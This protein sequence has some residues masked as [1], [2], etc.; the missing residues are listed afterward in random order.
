MHSL[1]IVVLI[2]LAAAPSQGGGD[3]FEAL[4]AADGI[5]VHVAKSGLFSGFA[6][7]HDFEVTRWRGSAAIPDRDPGRA[8][9]ELILEADS[10]RDREKG[11][12]SGDRRKVEAQAAGPEVLDAARAPEITYRAERVSLDPRSGADAGPARGTLH[13]QLTVRSRTRPVDATFEAERT[14][15]AW[16]VRGRARFKQSEFGI[17]PFSGY[18]GTVSVKDEI[19]VTFALTLQPGAGV[20]AGAPEDSDDD[21]RTA[22]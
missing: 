22:E 15:D 20:H 7:D 10:L 21:A 11:L 3:R 17:K 4:P 9:V 13:G 16:Q 8:S 1:T 14:A 6:H 2:A 19:E 12:S 5:R 18:G